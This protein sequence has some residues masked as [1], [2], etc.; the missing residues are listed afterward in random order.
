MNR[1]K[2]FLKILCAFS[3]VM[4]S[5]GAGT[6]IAASAERQEVRRACESDLQTLCKGVQPGGGRIISCLKQNYDK[7]SPGCQQALTKAKEARKASRQA[8]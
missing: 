7:L 1:T 3:I 2:D 5:L 4:S 6:A 8:Q